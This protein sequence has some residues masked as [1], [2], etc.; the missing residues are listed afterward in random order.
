MFVRYTE[1]LTSIPPILRPSKSAK[2]LTVNVPR[3]KVYSFWRELSNLPN[4]MSHLKQVSETSPTRSHWIAQTPGNLIP[5]EWNA[6]IT[7][8]ELG[9]YIGWQ[10]ITGSMIEHAGKITFTDALNAI[11]TEV[12]VELNY[13]APAGSIGRGITSLFNGLFEKMIREDIQGFKSYVEQA[14]FLN[15]AGLNM[16]EETLLG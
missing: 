11:G 9:S 1:P 10:S 4:F 13:F 12:H 8:E 16:P 2:S 14:D 5:L 15:Y 6:E 3:E 7:H